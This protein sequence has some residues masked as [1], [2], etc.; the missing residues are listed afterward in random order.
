M[1]ATFTVD[2]WPGQA[3]RGVVRQV[4]NN[5]QTVQNVVTYDAVIDVD[6]TDLKLRPGMTANVTVIYDERQSVLAVT[7]AA[8]RFHPPSTAAPAS[9]AAA[10]A[11]GPGRGKGRGSKKDD[12]PEARTV[13]LLHGNDPTPVSVHTGLT[14]GTYTEVLDGDVHEGDAVVVDAT[15]GDAT[16]PA[17]AGSAQLRRLF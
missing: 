3:F 12:A 9:Q 16:A 10:A 4:R 11:T 13:Y 17:S 15:G 6:N 14:D 5:P 1:P 2:A 7:N 8:L